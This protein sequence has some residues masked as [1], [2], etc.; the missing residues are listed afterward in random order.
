VRDTG[1]GI[2]PETLGKI[3]DPFFTTK[4]VGK[5]TGLGLSMSFGIVREHGGA[6]EV[7][8][9]VGVGTTFTVL[10]PEIAAPVAE[11]MAGV[12]AAARTRA[13]GESVLLVE[14]DEILRDLLGEVLQEEGYVVVAAAEPGEAL[15][16][17]R[18]HDGAID[19]VITDVVMPNMSGF[20]LAKELRSRQP[21][22]RVLY[23]SGYTDQV[24]ADHGELNDDDPFIRKPFGNDSLLEKVREVLDASPRR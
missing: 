6:I 16:S 11:P 19:L 15:R 4:E 12:E 21:N 17:A 3:F 5:G 2:P 7:Q 18:A 22:L 24:L 9:E 23:M 20:L 14:D 10:L 13:S 8:S 1:E